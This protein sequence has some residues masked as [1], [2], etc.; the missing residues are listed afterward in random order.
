MPRPRNKED[1]MIAATTNYEKLLV[2][3]ENRTENEIKM[4]YDFSADEKNRRRRSLR[5]FWV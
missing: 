3:I 1:L 4:R 2:L 5:R